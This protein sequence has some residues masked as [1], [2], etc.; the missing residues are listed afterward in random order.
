MFWVCVC[1]LRYPACNAHAPY[2]HLWPV[3]LYLFFPHY[4]INGTIFGEGGGGGENGYWTQNM[5]FEFPYNFCLKHFLFWEEW[6]EILLKMYIGIYVKFELFLPDF[7]ET[8]ILWTG[9]RKILKY[10]ISWKN[11]HL[12]PSCS[13]R[14]DGYTD[15][16]TKLMVAFRNI[17]KRLTTTR[18]Y[19]FKEIRL[20]PARILWIFCRSVVHR[21]P[22][23]FRTFFA[24]PLKTYRIPLCKFTAEQDVG[25]IEPRG[26]GNNS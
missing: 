21:R 18:K 12:Q 5:C 22:A 7:N 24:F 13:M 8:W 11:F 20:C 14:K 16:Q 25:I 6:S 23:T 19:N 15:R 26:G 1:S 10:R 4:L 17:W 3:R 9:F 2:C